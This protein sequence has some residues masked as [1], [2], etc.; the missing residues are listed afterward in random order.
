MNTAEYIVKRLEELG[1][2]DFFGLPGDYNFNIIYEV[3]N[4]P[5]TN[6]IGC[7]NELN[8][9]YAADGYARI[10]GYGALIT[11]YGVG[12]LSAINA[13]AGCMAENIPVV[14]I[15][16]LPNSKVIENKS[17]VHHNLQEV[18]YKNFF[19]M[20]KNVTS[21]SAFLTRDN[22]KLEIDRILKVLVREKKPVYIAIPEDIAEMEISD[23]FVSYDWISDRDT[24][25]TVTN[26]IAGKINNSARP[27][28]IGDDLIKRFDA[29]IEYNKFVE[30]TGI[31]VSNFL[32]G[33]NLVDMDLEN[34]IGGYFGKYRNPI[35]EK[36]I[37][38]T[39]CCITIGGIYSDLNTFGQNL[40]FD[41][42]KHIAIYG[43]YTYIDGVKYENIK[44]PELLEALTKCVERKEIELERPNTG[45][46]LQNAEK[47]E[48]TTS[49][50]YPRIQEFLKENDIVLT[51]TGTAPFGV[52]QVKCPPSVNFELQSLWGS[53]GWAT[54]ASL[55]ASIAK[56]SSR[57][58]LITGDGAH[59][60]SALEIGTMIKLGLK[61]IIIVINNG[62]YSTER[63][64][65]QNEEAKFNDIADMNYAKF[66]R[67]FSGDIWATQAT[68][69][70]DFDKALKVTQIMN[71]LCY[72]EACISPDDVPVLV[73]EF[74]NDIKNKKN[75]NEQNDFL[76]N[77]ITLTSSVNGFEYETVVHKTMNEDI[78][79]SKEEI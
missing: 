14:H 20:Y 4:N 15:V 48:L 33:K 12:E 32:M 65:S 50:I 63:L 30:K 21:A 53:I 8:A 55:G 57:V 11:T 61:P 25:E 59:Q 45:Y 42:N 70:D 71:K 1:V 7:T 54:P 46:K 58:V 43:N 18:N 79:E 34:Y 9:G 75:S 52:A 74:I 60:I 37:N 66:A 22:A 36:Y 49:Y 10:K 77:N 3:E 56:P 29:E 39:D 44:M 68:T 35:A 67:A 78:E 26:K 51:D 64:L 41:I 17:L 6:W 62:G 16:G 31:P 5:N 2:N 47:E 13:I 24:L 69:N 28:I 27:V 76:S 40:P 23:R 19:E 73:K 72:I 38:E